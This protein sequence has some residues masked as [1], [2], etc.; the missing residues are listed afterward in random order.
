MT[1]YAI[2]IRILE[3]DDSHLT[4]KH[5]KTPIKVSSPE[6]AEQLFQELCEKAKEKK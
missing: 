3:I 1:E 6:E 4:I 2:Q 5:S